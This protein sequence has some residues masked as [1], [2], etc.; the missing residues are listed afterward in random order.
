MRLRDWA[1]ALRDC[2]R[3]E[4]V[5]GLPYAAMLG[6]LADRDGDDFKL[7]M[8]YRQSLIGSPGRL[9]G[10]AI[11][12][13]LELAALATLLRALPDEEP[14]PVPK[15]ITVTVDF[16]R[17]GVERDTFAAA[18]IT[19]LGRRIAN[20]RAQAWQYDHSRPIATANLNFMLDKAAAG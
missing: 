7:V 20:V 2:G 12:G 3:S 16:M 14:F 17:E 11:A 15:P 18:T 10:G 6:V 4:P 8:P 9:H 5:T 13:L 19:R 1:A